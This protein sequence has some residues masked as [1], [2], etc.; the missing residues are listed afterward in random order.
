MIWNILYHLYHIIY[1]LHLVMGYLLLCNCLFRNHPVSKNRMVWEKKTFSDRQIVFRL[2][3]PEMFIFLLVFLSFSFSFSTGIM[4]KMCIDRMPLWSKFL[5]NTYFKKEKRF[6]QFIVVYL[7]FFL[8]F[9]TPEFVGEEIFTVSRENQNSFWKSLPRRSL[10]G[11]GR[12]LIDGIY[13]SKRKR[14]SVHFH[15]DSK[16]T[17]SI[18]KDVCFKTFS[19]AFFILFCLVWLL[20]VLLDQECVLNWDEMKKRNRKCFELWW[21]L[22]KYN[23]MLILYKKNFKA[24]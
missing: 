21:F 11:F 13:K 24:T 19:V 5:F 7:Y 8:F 10:V 14:G 20:F 4:V 22:L 23:W 12:S 3:F 15:E 1:I 16:D 18:R 2:P 9:S 6:N 17:S